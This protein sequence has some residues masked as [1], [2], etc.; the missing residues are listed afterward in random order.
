MNSNKQ[1]FN[2]T[3]VFEDRSIDFTKIELGM[4]ESQSMIHL[5]LEP[6]LYRHRDK[7]VDTITITKVNK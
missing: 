4:G 1:V 7:V 3:I 6:I 5:Y 2:I